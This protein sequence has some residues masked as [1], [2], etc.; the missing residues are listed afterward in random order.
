MKAT[1][2]LIQHLHGRPGVGADVLLL[3]VSY[4]SLAVDRQRDA[5]V[6]ELNVVKVPEN[7]EVGRLQVSVHHLLFGVQVEERLG[8]PSH[9]L[10]QG[11]V[12]LVH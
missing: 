6:A 5:K 12:T 11:E 9:H 7:K 1:I 2:F 10:V 8:G 3:R 4:F